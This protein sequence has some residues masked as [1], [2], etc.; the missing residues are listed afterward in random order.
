VLSAEDVVLAK[1]DWFRLGGEVSDRQWRDI[2]GVL[3]TQ[4]SALDIDYLRQWAQ[5]LDVAD[6][7]VQRKLYGA[8]ENQLKFA[9]LWSW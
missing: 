1:P 2:L 4:Q 8:N 9:G 5:T 6:L 7:S 3:K